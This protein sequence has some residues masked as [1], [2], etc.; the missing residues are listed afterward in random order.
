MNPITV[1]VFRDE[2]TADKIRVSN[3]GDPG[4]QSSTQHEAGALC[5]KDTAPRRLNAC[6][7]V[8][9]YF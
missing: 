1:E 4:V 7:T 9:S 8:S 5:R 2:T 3:R 6:Q